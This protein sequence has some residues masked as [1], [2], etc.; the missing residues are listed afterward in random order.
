V[1]NSVAASGTPWF[2]NF[3][4]AT[5]AFRVDTAI[6]GINGSVYQ[7]LASNS[8]G[9][10]NL[11]NMARATPFPLVTVELRT[12]VTPAE[13]VYAL[14]ATLGTSWHTAFSNNV[15]ITLNGQELSNTTTTHNATYRVDGYGTMRLPGSSQSLYALRIRKL[16]FY[17]GSPV[18]SFIFLSRGGAQVQFEAAD[19]SAR[20]GTININRKTVWN[21]SVVSDSTTDVRV[22]ENVPSEFALMQNYPN[23]FNP[24]T[25]INYQVAT[26][27]FVSLKVYNLLGQEVAALVNEV[28]APGTYALDWNAEGFPSGVY[29]YKMQSGSFTETRRMLLLR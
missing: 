1:F 17:N 11:G 21:Y 25:T 15:R 10:R 3:P 22:S 4:G 24:S 14:P 7:Y 12:T 6:Q 26:S 13:T 23:P 2:T 27:G 16:N 8:G 20:S 29:F 5:N 18:V 28:K 19:T 9:L